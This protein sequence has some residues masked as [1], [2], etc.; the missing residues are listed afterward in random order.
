ME[1]KPSPKTSCILNIDIPQATEMSVII[2][3]Q[4]LLILPLKKIKKIKIKEGSIRE[5]AIH[6]CTND[7]SKDIT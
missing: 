3:V 2:L 6:G 7:K 1:M 4:L 5:S